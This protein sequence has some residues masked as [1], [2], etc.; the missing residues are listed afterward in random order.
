[1][2]YLLLFCLFSLIDSSD[3][4]GNE[5]TE[6]LVVDPTAVP[7][8]TPTEIPTLW[9]THHIGPPSNTHDCGIDEK[10][11]V[12]NDQASTRYLPGLK[13][14][15]FEDLKFV[16]ILDEHHER[17]YTMILYHC[18]IPNHE[19]LRTL[20]YDDVRYY[21]KIPFH[22][23]AYTHTSISHTLELLN[24]R[25]AL[26]VAA[27]PIEW[28]TSPCL[29]QLYDYGYIMDTV[30]H[31]KRELNDALMRHNI[32]A[33]FATKD[34]VEGGIYRGVPVPV[35]WYNSTAMQSAESLLKYISLFFNEEAAASELTKDL[36]ASYTCS[37]TVAKNAIKHN[38]ATNLKV[39]WCD[40]GGKHHVV[41]RAVQNG[42]PKD[43]M[44]T[45]F[46]E[47]IWSC[48]TCPSPECSAVRDAGGHFLDYKK[49]GISTITVNNSQF[50][51][52]TEFM[53]MALLADVW[54]TTGNPYVDFNITLASL[55]H[56]DTTSMTF[57]WLPLS[58][59]PAVQHK[60]VYDL[61]LSGPYDALQDVPTE[62]D[63]LLQDVFSVLTP[64]SHDRI[65]LRNVFTEEIPT[66]SIGSCTGNPW[67]SPA[68]QATYCASIDGT[69]PTK[70]PSHRI[71]G[72][73]NS[74]HDTV[75]YVVTQL[76]VVI[77]CIGL[78]GLICTA[79]YNSVLYRSPAAV[80]ARKAL[81]KDGKVMATT[82][83][84]GP[85]SI[86]GHP[87]S[88]AVKKGRGSSSLNK[89]SYSQAPDDSRHGK[90]SSEHGSVVSSDID[91]LMSVTAG[92]ANPSMQQ[93]PVVPSLEVSAASK[94]KAKPKAW[95]FGLDVRS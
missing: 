12:Y 36:S 2:R 10:D 94:A 43:Q 30:S 77:M 33:T 23:V 13:V 64:S 3:L 44:R 78:F 91:P 73:S 56:E 21:F 34:E 89:S 4:L 17:S 41:D 20:G 88:K 25:I 87:K 47:D 22:A 59:V 79:I 31:D 75:K 32:D 55:V 63:A 1:M 35:N 85:L 48:R 84:L 81:G 86:H 51:E 53:E 6:E 54:I 5:T 39:M 24:L 82:S 18:N 57:G 26:K 15:Y 58:Y 37:S 92:K 61:K 7:T 11:Y 72:M 66:D 50:L 69:K 29:R 71:S 65:W 60:R 14:V 28:N 9:P 19:T 93:P 16:T 52:S 42:P 95:F 67:E 70:S 46:N 49:Y 80:M 90:I 45:E 83:S 74:V 8:L 76:A 62:P 27:S 68:F 38:N 40:Y